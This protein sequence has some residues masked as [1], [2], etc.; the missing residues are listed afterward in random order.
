MNWTGGRLQRHSKKTDKTVRRQQQ[1]FAKVRQ[2]QHSGFHASSSPFRPNFAS[3]MAS[4]PYLPHSGSLV[5]SRNIQPANGNS[6]RQSTLDQYESLAPVVRRLQS[7]KKRPKL[8]HLQDAALHAAR[9]PVRNQGSADNP[10]PTEGPQNLA[11]GQLRD[12]VNKSGFQEK[13]L[14]LLGQ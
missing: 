1:H 6:A 12:Q 5:K 7:L 3:E 2:R 9:S 4:L 13:K 14:H 11:S 8:V 10:V